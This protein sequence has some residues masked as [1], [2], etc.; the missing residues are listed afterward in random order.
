MLTVTEIKNPQEW[1]SDLNKFNSNIFITPEWIESFVDSEK[2]SIY[3]NFTENNIV[4]GKI[5][6]LRI[7]SYLTNK[8]I[9]FFYSGPA[10][11]GSNEGII[12]L[13]VDELLRYARHNKFIRLIVR[14]YDYK[15]QFKCK[16]QLFKIADRNEYL[17]D[18]TR[19]DEEI[20][21]NFN[22]QAIKKIKKS[23]K[24]KFRLIK[25]DSAEMIDKLI[26][27]MEETKKIRL[28][29][30][31]PEYSYFY[32]PYLDEITLN[33]IINNKITSL[34][35]VKADNEIL[36]VIIILNYNKQVYSFLIGSDIKAYKLGINYFLFYKLIF[37]LKEQNFEYLN[38][39]GCPP[40]ISAEG[41]VF[42]KRS[43]GGK[44]II[45]SGGSSNYLTIPHILLNPLLN[46]G[47]KLPEIPIIKKIKKC[48]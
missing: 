13:F 6:G 47:R 20:I 34:Y 35:Y 11:S 2:K 43:L 45:M 29:K 4:K 19:P 17:I 9:L 15:I 21:N 48:I 10:W 16:P 40:D 46:L 44:E 42:F 7:K 38:L 24:H 22:K 36:S 31:Y 33:K 5:A 41:L 32:I 25:G 23:E 1:K 3:L 12:P 8:E 39:G 27:L 28:S 26:L 14:S 37:G 30:G 18:L